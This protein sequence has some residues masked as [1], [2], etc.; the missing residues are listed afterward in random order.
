MLTVRELAERSGLPRSTVCAISKLTTWR[1]VA[2]GDAE[3]FSRACGVDLL[4]LRRHIE[5]VKHRM[6]SSIR[7]ASP[8][9]RKMIQ[10][11]FRS[12]KQAAR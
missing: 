1:S 8:I 6:K 7:N 4:R 10:D 9:Q 12:L 3:K 11:R 5:Y 2:I